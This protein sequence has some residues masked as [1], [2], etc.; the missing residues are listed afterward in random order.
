MRSFAADTAR[1]QAFSIN[2]TEVTSSLSNWAKVFLS[3]QIGVMHV[4]LLQDL[5][6]SEGC[7][8]ELALRVQQLKAELVLF[9]GLMS[10]VSTARHLPRVVALYSHTLSHWPSPVRSCSF[11]PV[12]VGAVLHF[13]ST[14]LSLSSHCHPHLSTERHRRPFLP[15]TSQLQLNV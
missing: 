5:Q 9:K 11:Q 8:D 15:A 14:Y 3:F 4:V 10:N 12:C 7:Q 13:S 6:E 1:C 2:S